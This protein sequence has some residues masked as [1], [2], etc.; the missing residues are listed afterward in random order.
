MLKKIVLAAAAPAVAATLALGVQWGA[1]ANAA[2]M[3]APNIVNF[4]AVT[5]IAN[6]GDTGGAGNTWANVDITRTLTVKTAPS[7]EQNAANSTVYVATVQD[8]GDL[9][10]IPGQLAPNQGGADAGSKVLH[11]VKGVM[12]GSTTYTFT[13]S[14]TD[15]PAKANVQ[16]FVNDHGTKPT[17]GPDSTSQ[18]YLQAFTGSQQ[19]SVTG[20]ESTNWGGWFYK[21]ACGE[22]WVDSYAGNDGQNLADGNITGKDCATPPPPGSHDYLYNGHVISISNNDVQLGWNY[23]FNMPKNPVNHEYC[24]MTRTFGYGFSTSGSPHIGFTC[25]ATNSSTG[26]WTGLAAGHT[27][28]MQIIPAFGTYGDPHPIP[29]AQTDWINLVTTR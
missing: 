18:W 2:P 20:G 15:I 1:A 19:S 21:T 14:D 3:P 10:T 23:R 24:A 17:S 25:S 13:A 26:Y 27:Y 4:T 5:H 28:D 9:V 12:E 16:G 7:S 11:A 22:T 6:N 8:Q 29:G